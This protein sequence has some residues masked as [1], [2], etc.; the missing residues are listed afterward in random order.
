M[1]YIKMVV[2]VLIF[3]ITGAIL[4]HEFAQPTNMLEDTK[5]ER[6]ISFEKIFGQ[7]NG[8]VQPLQDDGQYGD[9]IHTVSKSSSEI[10]EMYGAPIRKDPSAYGYEWW[11]YQDDD[12]YI[13]LGIENDMVTT[14]FA[15]GDA[16]LSEPFAIGS[17]Y[18]EM[19]EQFGFDE[20]ISYE[21]SWKKY[22]FLLNEEDLR[23][24]PMIQLTNDLYVI[25]YFDQFT[26]QLSSIRLMTIDV[27]LK[28][29]LYDMEYRGTLA[30]EKE[31]DREEWERIEAGIEKQIFD[32]TNMYRKRHGLKKLQPD[33]QVDEVAFLHS[34]DMAERNYF[35]HDTPEGKTVGDRLQA[36]QIYY[37]VSAE[38]IA[39]N[40]SDGPDVSEGWLNS[41]DHRK[42]V[43][44]PTFT[45]L[46]VGVYEK[47][48]TQNFIFK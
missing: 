28:Q 46:G 11:I 30:A 6:F 16:I 43:L 7:K 39:F 32:I 44:E 19:N 18:D 33:K 25:C 9:V 5:K 29:R 48:Y 1:R 17:T 2:V 4:L 10:I 20:Q 34:K 21:T 26:K 8:T 13:Q 35:S 3:C 36:K 12:A 24:K 37:R 14:V 41:E 23:I 22:V 42:A 31:Y 38:N 40:L 15:T 27:L 47:Y 45:T